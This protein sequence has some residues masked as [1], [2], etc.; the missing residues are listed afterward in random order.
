M[1]FNIGYHQ[2]KGVSNVL[3]TMQVVEC[4][5]QTRILYIYIVSKPGVSQLRAISE[6]VIT[7]FL[8][9]LTFILYNKWSALNFPRIGVS[10]Y[11]QSENKCNKYLIR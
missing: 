7:S 2:K 6:F 4:F 5:N 1:F 11:F 3:F 10:S 8:L 9:I